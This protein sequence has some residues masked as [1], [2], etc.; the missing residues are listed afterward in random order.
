MFIPPHI[1]KRFNGIGVGLAYMEFLKPIKG[2]VQVY[3]SGE[4]RDYLDAFSVGSSKS[5][6]DL[7]NPPPPTVITHFTCLGADKADAKQFN[8]PGSLMNRLQMEE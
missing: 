1:F 2:S 3:T 7:K 5:L 8:F 4:R 6:I